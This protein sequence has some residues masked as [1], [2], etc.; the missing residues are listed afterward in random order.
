MVNQTD[1]HH[2]KTHR[3]KGQR[4]KGAGAEHIAQ[5]PAD[6]NSDQ[7]PAEIDGSHRPHLRVAQIQRLAHGGQQ[8]AQGK[9][10]DTEAGKQPND[11]RQHNEISR[12]SRP[13]LLYR[14]IHMTE[15]RSARSIP[16]FITIDI[17]LSYG[18]V[19]SLHRPAQS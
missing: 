14:F 13:Y 2:G 10:A 18:S 8:H 17:T 16:F 7:I 19:Q 6:K 5:L 1:R 15:N 4:N 3:G 9:S 12:A 11:S